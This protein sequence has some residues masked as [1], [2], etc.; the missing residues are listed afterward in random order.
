MVWP[1]Q[2][3][4][5]PP[6]MVLSTGKQQVCWQQHDIMMMVEGKFDHQARTRA[7]QRGGCWEGPADGSDGV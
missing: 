4:D 2:I 6:V 1:R 7:R 3:R 5:N